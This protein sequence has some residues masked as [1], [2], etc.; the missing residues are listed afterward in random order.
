MDFTFSSE[1]QAAVESVRKFVSTELEPNVEQIEKENRL[2]D[3]IHKKMGE[4]GLWG[5]T[6]PEEQDGLGMS[7]DCLIATTLEIARISAAAAYSLISGLSG[8]EVLRKHASQEVKDQYYTKMLTGELVG[9][10]AFTEPGTGAD[11]KQLTTVAK[12]DGDHITLN[13]T[14]RFITNAG[15]PGPMVVWAKEADTDECSAFVIDKFCEGFSLSNPWE[16]IGTAGSPA[17]DVFLDNVVIPKKNRIGEKGKGFQILLT[18][19]AV[20]K[21][22]HGAVAVGVMEA[23]RNK[24]LTYANEKLHR[25]RPISEKFQATQIKLARICE[26]IES[27]KWM[28]YYC[29]HLADKGTETEEFRAYASMVKAYTADLAPETVLLAMNVMGPYGTMKEYDVERYLRDAGM[30][31]HVEVVSDVQRIIYA[32]YVTGCAQ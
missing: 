14:K 23:A 25:G 2:P 3:G 32:K 19:S 7:H 15:Y 13:G 11:P 9:C 8:I 12:E 28:V 21:M 22:I 16:K 18:E 26:K 1:Q 10:M 17:Y 20:G 30:G 24:A 27:A 6:I 5:M 29:A 31:P 4:V